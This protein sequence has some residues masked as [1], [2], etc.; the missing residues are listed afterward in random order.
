[1]FSPDPMVYECCRNAWEKYR[2]EEDLPVRR[3]PGLVSNDDEVLG[4]VRRLAH[5][6]RRVLGARQPDGQRQL[7]A[8][9][10]GSVAK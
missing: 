5:M 7:R 6:L 2:R 8:A 10:H 9:E 1:M 3:L 4:G